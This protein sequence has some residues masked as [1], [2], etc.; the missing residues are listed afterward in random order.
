[1]RQAEMIE[2]E[3][4]RDEGRN[5][6]MGRRNGVGV[7]DKDNVRRVVVAKEEMEDVWKEE[8]TNSN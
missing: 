7:I 2:E 6:R 5:K 4:E 3:M 8:E 1:M